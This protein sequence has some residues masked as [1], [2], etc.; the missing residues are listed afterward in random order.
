MDQIDSDMF[1]DV[2]AGLGRPDKCC[3]E[4]IDANGLPLKYTYS[5]EAMQTPLN[6]PLVFSKL[7]FTDADCGFGSIADDLESSVFCGKSIIPLRN[8]DINC[9]ITATPPP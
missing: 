6:K 9:S 4:T 2:M 1:M 7:G 3:I 5:K 8:Y